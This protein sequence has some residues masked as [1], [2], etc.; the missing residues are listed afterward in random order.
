MKQFTLLLVIC[1]IMVSACSEQHE[2]LEIITL[3]EAYPGDLNS[4]TKIIIVD[5][6]SG[7]RRSFTDVDD[8][9]LWLDQISDLEFHPDPNQESRNG[10]R[11]SVSL[12]EK[13]E[14]MFGFTLNNINGNYYIADSRL[15]PS[16]SEFYLSKDDSVD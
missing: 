2:K 14:R 12:Y 8:I 5:G 3:A 7:E 15:L 4:I 10:F 9:Q 13:D 6:G 16:I 11:Y 1:F